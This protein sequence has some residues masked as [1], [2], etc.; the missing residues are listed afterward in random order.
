MYMSC[1]HIMIAGGSKKRSSDSNGRSRLRGRQEVTIAGQPPPFVGNIPS[2]P[3]CKTTDGSG[4]TLVFPDPGRYVE[5][6]TTDNKAQRKPPFNCPGGSLYKDGIAIGQLRQG[7]ETTS[8][9]AGAVNGGGANWGAASGGATNGGV[10]NGDAVNG[11]AAGGGAGNGGAGNG[12]TNGGAGGG[13]KRK[14]ISLSCS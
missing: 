14:L 1:A 7:K 10:T 3:E 11:G 12:A 13:A 4:W 6:G 9:G 2:I 8:G 5:Y